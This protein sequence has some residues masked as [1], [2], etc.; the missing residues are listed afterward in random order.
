LEHRD[1][2]LPAEPDDVRPGDP[3]EA[4]I[5]GRGPDLAF[6]DDEEMSRVAGRDEAVRIEHQRLVRAGL[7]RLDAGGD[8]VQLRV[9][10]ELW[11]LHV[12]KAAPHVDREQGDPGLDDRG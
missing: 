7:D 8:A 9:R 3:A 10:V 1:A 5:A 11:I 6:A 12:R 2:V 4:I